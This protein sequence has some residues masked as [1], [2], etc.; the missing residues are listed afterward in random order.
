MKIFKTNCCDGIYNSLDVHFTST[1][2][3]KC[4]HCIDLEYAGKGI[5]KPNVKAI[6]NTIMDNSNK[7]DDVLFLGGEPCLYLEELV[8]CVRRIKT[9]TK[10]KV[11]VTSAMPKTCY[12]NQKL[13]YDLLWLLDGFNISAQHH[14]EFVADKIRCTNSQYDRQKFYASLPLKEKIRININIVKPFLFKKYDIME[15]LIHYDKMGFN[16]I[17]VS[18]IQHG[19]EHFVSFEKLFGL[20]M[21][22][23]YTHGCQTYLDMNEIIDEFKT[24]VLLKRSC[25][26]CEDTLKATILDGVKAIAKTF[27]K[28]KNHYGVVYEDGTLTKGWI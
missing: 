27:M 2:D 26:M 14:H 13:F 5:G 22:S 10:L 19:K 6:Y 28:Q 17:K 25:F 9:S 11:Y 7:V 1:C 8:D 20:D 16:S 3:N 23:P 21:K 12:D 18:E 4:K 24:P 15:C